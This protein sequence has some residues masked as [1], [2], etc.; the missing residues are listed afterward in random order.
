MPEMSGIEVCRQV[1]ALRR[2]DD[3]IALLM[4]TGQE[5]KED[6]TQALRAVAEMVRWWEKASATVGKK[7]EW[8]TNGSSTACVPRIS[9][10]KIV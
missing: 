4:L 7:R 6:L 5:T 9:I 8:E 10:G 2:M 1:R 3:S